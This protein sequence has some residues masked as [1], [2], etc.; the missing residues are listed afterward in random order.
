MP[1]VKLKERSLGVIGL[2]AIGVL[3]ADAGQPGNGCIWIRSLCLCRFCMIVR[4]I[5]HAKTVDMNFIRNVITLPSMFRL[6]KALKGMIDR[7]ALGLMKKG[8]CGT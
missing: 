5:H 3:V 4:S 2:G 6:L 8:R 7:D 1:V